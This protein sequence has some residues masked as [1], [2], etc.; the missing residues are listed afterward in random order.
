M[1]G[2]NEVTVVRQRRLDTPSTRAV[3]VVQ[4][5]ASLPV[6]ERK[7]RRVTVNPAGPRT[8][9]YT[10]SGRIAGFLTWRATFDFELTEAGFHRCFRSGLAAGS[11]LR[12]TATALATI[13]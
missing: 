7:A 2:R 12:E 3:S 9:R 1:A 6:W 8:G 13:S 5:L 10:A 11:S 4:H